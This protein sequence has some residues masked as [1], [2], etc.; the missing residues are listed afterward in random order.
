MTIKILS[1]VK[2]VHNIF[3]FCNGQ[4]VVCYIVTLSIY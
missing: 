3:N 1:N 4:L 2:S